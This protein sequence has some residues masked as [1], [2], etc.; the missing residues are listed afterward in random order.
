M[1]IYNLLSLFRYAKYQEIAAKGII[2]PNK[3]P[4]TEDA[5]FK[6]WYG[7]QFCMDPIFWGWQR[8]HSVFTPI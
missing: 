8:I 1:L 5:A 3:L 6:L 2:D 7:N 4:P